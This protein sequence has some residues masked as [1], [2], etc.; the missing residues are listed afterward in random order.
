MVPRWR[1]AQAGKVIGDTKNTAA[2]RGAATQPGIPRSLK[3]VKRALIAA[4]KC[5][6]SRPSTSSTGLGFSTDEVT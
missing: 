1:P 3:Y 5:L 4:E 6:Q 2:V